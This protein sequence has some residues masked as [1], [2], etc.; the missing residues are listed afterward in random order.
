MVKIYKGNSRDHEKELFEAVLSEK[1]HVNIAA[2]DTS[3]VVMY[4]P[5]RVQHSNESYISY[6]V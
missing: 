2:N 1:V 5:K 4:I 3:M 6:I